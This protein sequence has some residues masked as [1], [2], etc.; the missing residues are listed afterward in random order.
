MANNLVRTPWVIDTA[1]AT[2]IKSGRTWV[3]AFVF[4]G[5]AA[6][7]DKAIIKDATRAIVLYTLDGNADLSPIVISFGKAVDIQSIAVTTL[8]SGILTIHV[9]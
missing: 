3:N 8:S 7:T 6:G 9:D 1:S 2:T 5:Y 4:S